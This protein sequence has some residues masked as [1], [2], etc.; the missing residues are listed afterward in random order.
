MTTKDVGDRVNVRYL[1]YAAGVASTATVV[2]TVTAP[3]GTTTTPSV[4]LTAPNQYDASFTLTAAGS[5]S[6]RWDVS[7]A[8]IDK[9]YGAVTAANPAAPTYC[10]MALLK[11]ALG[12]SVTD[13]TRDDLLQQALVGASRSVEQY[14]DDRRF[15][16]DLT[17]T[18]RTFPTARTVISTCDGQRLKVDDIG[19][20]TMTVEVGDGTTWTTTTDYEVYPLNALAK[21]QAITAL[22]TTST[23]WTANRRVRVTARWGWPEIPA[24]VEQATLLQASRLFRRKDSPEGVAGSADWGL[25]RVPN[26]DPDVKA[27]LAYLTIPF[28]AA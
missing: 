23:N 7:G 12:V 8:V 14:C 18:A 28:K 15:Y 13:T 22:F 26:M 1:A 19:H 9:Q 20:A 2:L 24:A 11:A 3:D 21:G 17:S 4:T 16:L 10:T 5:W 27:L 25:V 6:W